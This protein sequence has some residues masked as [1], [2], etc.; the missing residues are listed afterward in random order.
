VSS[1]PLRTLWNV[2]VG[3]AWH[4]CRLRD[5][6]RSVGKPVRMR[7]LVGCSNY[8]P[9]SWRSALAGWLSP[10]REGEQPR[11]APVTPPVDWMGSSR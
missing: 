9:R 5:G 2:P 3:R 8:V 11:T 6:Q 4:A 10:A 1:R 7:L